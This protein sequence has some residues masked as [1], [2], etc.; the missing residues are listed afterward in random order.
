MAS[1]NIR[2]PVK[3]NV[4]AIIGQQKGGST[5]SRS[6]HKHSVRAA[7]DFCFYLSFS[8]PELV[9]FRGDVMQ[10]NML[11]EFII[12]ANNLNFSNTAQQLYITQPVLSKH[13][14]MLEDHLGAKLFIRNNH[15]VTLTEIG[16]QFLLDAVEIVNRYDYA[17]NKVKLAT[18]G[19]KSELKVGYLDAAA[20]SVLVSAVKKFGSEFPNADL[21]LHAFEYGDLPNAL[22]NFDIDIILTLN[23]DVTIKEWC[24]VSSIYRDYLCVVVPDGHPFTSMSSVNLLD[25][26]SESVI[27]PTSKQFPSYDTFLKE[28]FAS[29]GVNPTISV[30]AEHVDTL[31][32]FVEAGQG[33]TILPHHLS[34]Y[35]NSKTHFIPLIGEQCGFDLIAAWQ[36][37]NHNPLIPYF[38][39][40]LRE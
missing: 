7:R 37:S 1:P 5:T 40:L 35:A 26:D 11:R 17:V 29:S 28:L 9:T 6:R 20:R 22:K 10:I 19:A 36:K 34:A 13:I 32:L 8:K 31:L 21:K 33:I 12:L 38:V 4:L 2:R 25:I 15:M 39:N 23:F 30:F 27:M 18:G 14:S 3:V 24:N 16:S